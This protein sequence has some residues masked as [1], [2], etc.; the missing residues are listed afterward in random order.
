[1]RYVAL[2]CDYDGTL[3]Q[4]GTVSSAT[5][6]ALVRVRA[7]G[8]KILLITGRI[9]E[10]LRIVCDCLELFD[11]V[12]AENGAVLYNPATREQ[13]M[14]GEPPPGVFIQTLRE[15]G[16]HPLAAGQVIVAARQPHTSVVLQAIRDLEL[17]LQIVPNREAIMVL[18]VGVDKGSGLTVALQELD[19]CHRRTVGVGDAEND[20][21]LLDACGLG[22]AVANAGP[23]L[24]NAADF[25]TRGARGAGVAEL[26]EKLLLSKPY[27]AEPDSHS[28]APPTSTCA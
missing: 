22:V 15:R 9:I 1:M 28:A 6:D 20:L 13:R 26:I 25:V 7:S 3:A 16:V 18:P 4:C 19:L 14:L 24:K 5:V 21:A 8:R 23:L 27:P 11:R 2:C 12:V 10:D 17:S